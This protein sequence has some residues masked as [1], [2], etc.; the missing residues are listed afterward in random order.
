MSAVAVVALLLTVGTPPWVTSPWTSTHNPGPPFPGGGVAMWGSWV[1]CND[2]GGIAL[3]SRVWPILGCENDSSPEYLEQACSNSLSVQES[4]TQVGRTYWPVDGRSH[5]YCVDNAGDYKDCNDARFE[6]HFSIGM[7]CDGGWSAY[8][9]P[10]WDVRWAT[11]EPGA[12]RTYRDFGD[13]DQATDPA[14]CYLE[15]AFINVTESRYPIF[16][17]GDSYRQS[18]TSQLGGVDSC[19]ATVMDVLNL[20]DLEGASEHATQTPT[21]PPTVF[22]TPSPTIAIVPTPDTDG[23]ERF[24]RPGPARPIH[25]IIFPWCPVRRLT[26]ANDMLPCI[27]RRRFSAVLRFQD[28]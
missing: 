24:T 19:W 13:C 7:A 3:L 23:K 22:T 10:G 18:W 20:L 8:Q 9:Y 14:S 4:H 5:G 6:R 2:C 21:H 27:Y 25:P 11:N 16:T 17:G 1:G 26:L 28:V 12:L 15:Q